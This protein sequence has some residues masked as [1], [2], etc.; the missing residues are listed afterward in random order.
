MSC[1]SFYIF[2]Y[3]IQEQEGRTSPAQE[4]RAGPSGRGKVLG[5][6]GR[7]VNTEQ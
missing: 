3:R 6:G 4:E 1:F 2:S 7:R 5:K